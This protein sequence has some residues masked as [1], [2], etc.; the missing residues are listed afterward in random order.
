MVGWLDKRVEGGRRVRGEG[1]G[2]WGGMNS[3]EIR[4]LEA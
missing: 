2:M 3:D 4:K 1:M